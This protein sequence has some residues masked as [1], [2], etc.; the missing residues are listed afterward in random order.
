MKMDV[1]CSYYDSVV[2]AAKGNPDCYLHPHA[3][4]CQSVHHCVTMIL[5][6]S[7]IVAIAYA[8]FKMIQERPGPPS[9]PRSG[10]LFKRSKFIEYIHWKSNETK[11]QRLAL[12]VFGDPMFLK[13]QGMSYIPRSFILLLV[14]NAHRV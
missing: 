4:W 11:K 7:D 3:P 2:W 5:E 10:C 1:H 14:Q 6:P 9:I 12:S 8:S 13:A